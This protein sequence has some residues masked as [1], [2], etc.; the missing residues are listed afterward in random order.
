[1]ADLVVRNGTIVDRTGAPSFVGD[2]ASADGRVAAVGAAVGGW[3]PEGPA[4]ADA[5][6]MVGT[7]GWVAIHPRYAGRAPGA[8]VRARGPRPG[9]RPGV[10]G[11]GG[12]GLARVTADR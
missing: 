6:G 1:M 5:T 11:N 8:G 4:G 3:V 7:P 2:A 10:M 12:G 9:D